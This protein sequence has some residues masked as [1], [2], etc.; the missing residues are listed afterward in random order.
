M[1]HSTR[2]ID[3][4]HRRLWR[5]TVGETIQDNKVLTAVTAGG[6]SVAIAGGAAKNKI[7]SNH[8]QRDH[9]CGGGDAGLLG[10]SSRP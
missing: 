2:P 8:R 7:F 1:T 5:T 4:P 9:P 10:R 3:T 6:A